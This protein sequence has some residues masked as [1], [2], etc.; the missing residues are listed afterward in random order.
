MESNELKNIPNP[1]RQFLGTLASGVAATGLFSIL[2]PLAAQ[3][4]NGFFTGTNNDPDEWFKQIK[5]KHRVVF[6]VPQRAITSGQ[7]AVFYDGHRVLGGGW[8]R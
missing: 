6:D 7:G 8:I 1:R 2:S 5:G 4:E 3:A